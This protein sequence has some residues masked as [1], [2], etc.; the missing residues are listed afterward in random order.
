[1]LHLDDV[2]QRRTF[3]SHPDLARGGLQRAL[4]SRARRCLR[5]AR[6]ELQLGSPR[7][8]GGEFQN[9]PLHGAG[10]WGL[11]EPRLEWSSDAC[12]VGG[13]VFQ[14]NGREPRAAAFDI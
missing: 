3:A 13:R 5:I 14:E 9:Q 12:A 7:R 11:L 10:R 8:E 4:L 6:E 1:W 2:I